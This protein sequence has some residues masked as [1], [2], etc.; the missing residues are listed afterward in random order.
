MIV[1]EFDG[2]FGALWVHCGYIEF[3]GSWCL[4]KSVFDFGY[5]VGTLILGDSGLPLT[6]E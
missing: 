6:V 5:I 1:I 3:D 4:R 2:M